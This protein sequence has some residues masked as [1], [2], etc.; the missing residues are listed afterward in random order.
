ML[1]PERIILMTKMASYEEHEGKKNVAIGR[2]FRGD[3]LALQILKAILCATIAFCIGFGLFLLYDF[4]TFMQ[5]IYQ[6]DLLTFG[7]NVLISYGIIVVAY[8]AV[9]YIIC[10]IR[11]AKVKKSLK[12]YYQNLKKLNSLY[13]E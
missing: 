7:K 10:S 12:H 8:S 1:N 5:E 2:Y 9:C 6:M 3:Y 13:S 4:E 11:Y